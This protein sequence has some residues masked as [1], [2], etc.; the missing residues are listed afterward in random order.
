[1]SLSQVCSCSFLLRWQGWSKFAPEVLLVNLISIWVLPVGVVI[2][3]LGE[4]RLCEH[5]VY[6][7]VVFRDVKQV[8][9]ITS[10]RCFG[11]N[12]AT[13]LISCDRAAGYSARHPW[14]WGCGARWVRCG[15]RWWRERVWDWQQRHGW[16]MKMM[17]CFWWRATL[18]VSH[19]V[20]CNKHGKTRVWGVAWLY[21]VVHSCRCATDIHDADPVFS[22]HFITL[23]RV[24]IAGSCDLRS[25][26]KKRRDWIGCGLVPAVRP[27]TDSARD[28]WLPAREATRYRHMTDSTMDSW[29]SLENVVDRHLF[30]GQV[31][32]HRRRLGQLCQGLL[33]ILSRQTLAVVDI[34]W[35]SPSGNK[36]QHGCFQNVGQQL[37]H[38]ASLT[39]ASVVPHAS[40]PQQFWVI[41]AWTLLT[42]LDTVTFSCLSGY[43]WR[44]ALRAL[45][46]VIPED[47]RDWKYSSR[48]TCSGCCPAGTFHM[49]KLSS[50]LT[51]STPICVVW[52]SGDCAAEHE[53][54][55]SDTSDPVVGGMHTTLLHKGNQ[56][57]PKNTSVLF[58]DYDYDS[59]EWGLHKCQPCPT[60]SDVG[61]VTPT[62]KE[63]VNAVTSLPRQGV[64]SIPVKWQMVITLVTS[65]VGTLRL[66][67]I[68]EFMNPSIH[69][70]TKNSHFTMSEAMLT[71]FKCV[72]HSFMNVQRASR[73]SKKHQ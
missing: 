58:I 70:R 24:A 4:D 6:A 43:I 9:L 46:P 54:T 53:G 68:H 14:R 17:E 47:E 8:G 69:N 33:Q 20:Q 27:P 16:P 73:R 31:R 1:M 29:R 35:Q 40:S 11:G 5:R 59:S 25:S 22:G 50:E 30:S 18:D 41:V 49:L 34:L 15:W 60:D 7:L 44:I 57:Q 32:K 51:D 23:T 64:W 19:N 38:R 36:M 65:T 61:V 39:G 67:W 10:E 63:S 26:K 62:K 71:R 52:V 72:L 66:P 3:E 42:L 55:D 12:S 48:K 2:D 21:R 45:W 56:L 13:L 28:S 37:S